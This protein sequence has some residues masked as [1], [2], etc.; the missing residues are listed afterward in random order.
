MGFCVARLLMR[1]HKPC[2]I[3]WI[4]LLERAS[5]PLRASTI[6]SIKGSLCCC[7]RKD[8]RINRLRRLRSWDFL[9]CFLAITK[10]KRAFSVLLK[11]HNNKKQGWLALIGA[12]ANNALN[13]FASS[14]RCCLVNKRRV[15][16]IEPLKV[17]G[18]ML[19][20]ERNEWD[21]KHLQR[22]W[23]RPLIAYDLWRDGEPILCGRDD[24]PYERGN[25]EY[26]YALKCWVGMFFS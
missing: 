20:D 4:S 25:R 13:S 26:A 10:P 16:G 18:A 22:L 24:Q 6:A 17:F 5:A 15:S 2:K 12:S 23:L 3:T 9:I 19:T 11:L 8:S 21:T 14:R 7:R 1:F